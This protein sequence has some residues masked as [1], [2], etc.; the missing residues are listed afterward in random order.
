M[1]QKIKD[2]IDKLFTAEKI[3]AGLEG[4]GNEKQQDYWKSR[5][6]QLKRELC[7]DLGLGQCNAS[8]ELSAGGGG[9]DD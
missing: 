4:G 9:D 2:N 3:L 8:P 5:I 1:N 7:K 6:S